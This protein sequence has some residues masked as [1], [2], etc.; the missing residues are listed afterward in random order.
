MNLFRPRHRQTVMHKPM[1][2]CLGLILLGGSGGSQDIAPRLLT[3]EQVA[4][5]EKNAGHDPGK[6][7][8]LAKQA[9]EKEAQALLRKILKILLESKK[10]Q[11]DA[12]LTGQF[13][14]C[15]ERKFASTPDSV[16]EVLEDSQAN[17]SVARQVYFRRYSEQWIYEAPLRLW[18]SVTYKKGEGRRLQSVRPLPP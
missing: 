18:V 12:D 15:L 4:A 16:A 9:E 2:I 1:V 17:K 14:T 8:R 7:I 13:I 5:A 10:F 3:P 6:L 11:T